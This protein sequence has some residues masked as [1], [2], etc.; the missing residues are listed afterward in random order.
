MSLWPGYESGRQPLVSVGSPSAEE[1][2][3]SGES[4]MVVISAIPAAPLL[5]YLVLHHVFVGTSCSLNVQHVGSGQMDEHSGA[6]CCCSSPA[7][8]LLSALWNP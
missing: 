8:A 4:W 7:A 6:S 5:L 2:R 3:H 1:V